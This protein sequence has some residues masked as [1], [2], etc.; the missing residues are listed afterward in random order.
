MLKR[1]VDRIRFYSVSIR[2]RAINW[3]LNFGLGQKLQDRT[4]KKW[5]IQIELVFITFSFE[6]FSK[7]DKSMY[8][9]NHQMIKRE[10]NR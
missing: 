6:T 1:H 7:M 9:A 5:N 2:F 10:A 4:Q 8:L 3:S